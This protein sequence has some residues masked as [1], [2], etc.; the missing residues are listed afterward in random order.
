MLIGGLQKFTLSD[1]PGIP[2][3]I[4]FTQGCNFCCPYCHNHQLIPMKSDNLLAPETILDFL[5]TKAGKLKGVV[6][7][8]GEPTLQADL[9]E[10]ITKIKSLG[11][12]VKLDSNGSNPELLQK[13]IDQRLVDYIAMDLKAPYDKYHL[14]CGKKINLQAIQKS[15]AIIKK[16]GVA[17]L[18]RTTVY[19]KYLQPEDIA[20]IKQEISQDSPY[21]TQ[22][23][24]L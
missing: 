9:G 1:F 17:H 12:Q 5:R 19:E 2:A 7:T 8:G 15:V 6:I 10:T 18:F 20:R 14:L 11:Y 21:K 13:L 16:S 22:V 4:I 3:A 23:C 24:N